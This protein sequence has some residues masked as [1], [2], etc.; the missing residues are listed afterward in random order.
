MKRYWQC[1]SAA[2]PLPKAKRNPPVSAGVNFKASSGKYMPENL[3]EKMTRLGVG[4]AELP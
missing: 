2:A 3:I 4:S 1:L